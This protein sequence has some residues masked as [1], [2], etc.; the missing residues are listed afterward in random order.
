LAEKILATTAAEVSQIRLGLGWYE[1]GNPRCALALST[2]DQLEGLQ[3]TLYPVPS[4]QLRLSSRL[5]SS[6]L[7][8]TSGPRVISGNPQSTP[9]RGIIYLG[10]LGGVGKDT[11]A[12]RNKVLLPQSIMAP[13]GAALFS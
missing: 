6:A 13:E 1:V 4:R 2:S 10:R 9:Q 5:V 12:W 11:K 8:G 3:G 7:A